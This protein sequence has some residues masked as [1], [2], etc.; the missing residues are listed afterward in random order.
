MKIVK[1][2]FP[3]ALSYHPVGFTLERD[4]VSVC[5]KIK[6]CKGLCTTWQNTMLEEDK[7][8]A[9]LNWINRII[10]TTRL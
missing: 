1:L 4:E 10:Y 5:E 6:G 8:D 2:F 3:T 9:R 7:E